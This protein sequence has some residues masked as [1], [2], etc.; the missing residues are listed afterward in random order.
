MYIFS[1]SCN[2]YA[3]W[4]PRFWYLFD[5]TRCEISRILISVSYIYIYMCVL[6]FLNYNMYVYVCY[7]YEIHLVLYHLIWST[8]VFNLSN[9]RTTL[10]LIHTFS[11]PFVYTVTL[12]YCLTHD[13]SLLIYDWLAWFTTFHLPE[14]FF[15]FV[16]HFIYLINLYNINQTYHF[17]S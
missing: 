11:D 5:A 13:L 12:K 8:I 2:P 6:T 15:F 3:E 17:F 4:W 16:F 9:R 10:D 1:A 14:F 7:Y